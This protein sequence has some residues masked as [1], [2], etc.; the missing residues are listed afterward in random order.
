MSV[1]KD[2]R[3]EGNLRAHILARNHALYVIQITQNEKIFD[4]MYHQA[5]T[6]DLVRTSK[7]IFD[8]LWTANGIKVTSRPGFND[9]RDLYHERRGLI[10][11]AIKLCRTMLSGIEIAHKAFHLTTKRVEYWSGLVIEIR[12]KARA[13]VDSDYH[14]YKEYY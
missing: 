7:Q 3:T 8:L 14:R 10:E 6:D 11:E 2:S 1:P 12:N 5:I 4:P 13:W 9:R